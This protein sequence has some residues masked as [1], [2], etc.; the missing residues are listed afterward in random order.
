MT[1]ILT[2]ELRLALSDINKSL[3]PIVVGPPATSVPA[4]RARYQL[5]L[6]KQMLEEGQEW[7]FYRLKLHEFDKRTAERAKKVQKSES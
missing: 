1:T 7:R 5:S 4:Q 3:E 6:V 2:D